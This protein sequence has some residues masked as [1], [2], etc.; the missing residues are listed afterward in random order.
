MN[1]T[2]LRI[3]LVGAFSISA[4][5]VAASDPTTELNQLDKRIP[6]PLLPHMALHQKQNMRE[7]LESVQ[8]IIAGLSKKDF[9]AIAESA[10][11]MGFTPEMGQMCE[12]MGAGAAGFT[13]KAIHF[14]K[15]A[16][17]IVLAA[18][19]RDQ[20][21]VLTALKGTLTQCTSCH[22][23][24]RQQIVDEEMMKV[25]VDKLSGHSH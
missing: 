18:K 2:T 5:A 4:L 17:T 7:H 3:F 11:K 13:E 6:V 16:D 20:K 21:G 9:K 15:T 12:H 22:A 8:G 10:S 19:H 23:T 24:Y 1:H 14:H 25:F